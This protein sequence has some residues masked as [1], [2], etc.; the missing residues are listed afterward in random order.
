MND[1]LV[2]VS[3]EVVGYDNK[4]GHQQ[5]LTTIVSYFN[6]HYLALVS[7]AGLEGT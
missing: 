6:F 4:H 3:M 7:F 1:L 5:T 2:V